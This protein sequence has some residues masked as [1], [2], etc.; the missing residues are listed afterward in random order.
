MIVLFSGPSGGGKNTLIDH[1]IHCHPE[2]YAFLPTLTTRERRPKETNGHP[3]YF[4]SE[5]EFQKRLDEGEFYEHQQVHG[6]SYGTSRVIL[7][8]KLAIGKILLK[9]IDVYGTMNLVKVL[10]HEH[11]LLTFFLRVSDR[12]ILIERLMARGEQE[13]DFR[14]ER[15]D[16]E[17]SF[18]KKYNYIIENLVL[19]KTISII[20]AIIDFEQAKKSPLPTR[21]VSEIQ[22]ELVMKYAKMMLEGHDFDP[23]EVAIRDGNVRIIDGHH[24]FLASLNAG[25][26]IARLVVEP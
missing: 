26:P 12:K 14:L 10:E 4:V 5:A 6:K 1:L 19:E 16:L 13:I 23:I 11:R 20:N 9:D 22:D 18:A 24:R 8:M 21:N 7:N 2:K 25:R 17:N 15:F 3:Y